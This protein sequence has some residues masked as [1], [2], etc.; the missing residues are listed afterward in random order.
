MNCKDTKKL[1]GIHWNCC[2]TCHDD[3][4]ERGMGVFENYTK[5]EDLEF[6]SCCTFPKEEITDKEW[7][8][9]ENKLKVIK[10]Q[11]RNQKN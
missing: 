9:F 5:F 7:R 8:E 1:L 4:Y 11:I 6:E 3:P 2:N 10:C